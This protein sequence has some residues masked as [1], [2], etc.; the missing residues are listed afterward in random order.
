MPAGLVSVRGRPMRS[1]GRS[2]YGLRITCM[3]F[4]FAETLATLMTVPVCGLF[5][6]IHPAW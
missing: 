1:I 2:G 3:K 6:L 5:T 4:P